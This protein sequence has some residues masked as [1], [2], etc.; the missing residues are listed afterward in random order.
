MTIAKNKIAYLIALALPFVVLG[1]IT[2]SNHHKHNSGELWHVEIAGYDPRD[3]IHGRFLRY[4]INWNEYGS[5]SGSKSTTDALCLN[6]SAPDSLT[7]AISQINADKIDSARCDSVLIAGKAK[8]HWNIA[9][10]QYYIPEEYANALDWAFGQTQYKFTI[11]L[12]ISDAD[13]LSVTDLYINGER[14][15]KAIRALMAAYNK[16]RSGKRD[17]PYTWRFKVKDI[18]PYY[19]SENQSCIAYDLDWSQYGLTLDPYQNTPDLCLTPSPEDAK[20]PII[21]MVT[22]D[23]NS[24]QCTSIAK[25]GPWDNNSWIKQ[26]KIICR[27]GQL[28]KFLIAQS[29]IKD[30]QYEI[31]STI[32]NNGDF[33]SPE[34]RING[35]NI[36]D[37]MKSSA[38]SDAP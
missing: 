16:T 19:V 4:R 30:A 33:Y 36:K 28:G 26:P 13:T 21:S 29:K 12:R 31:E 7:P 2:L 37:S 5:V 10:R 25:A 3:L 22:S 20:M 6:R 23:A 15:N 35:Q 24:Q 32:S 11:D 27:S 17:E 18:N 14:M 34:L 9:L 1:Y 38:V 8:D